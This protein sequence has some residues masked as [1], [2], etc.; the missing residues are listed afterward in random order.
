[1]NPK[2]QSSQPRWLRQL[3][4]AAGI[5]AGLA[6]AA[7]IGMSGGGG[8]PEPSPGQQSAWDKIAPRL[9]TAEQASRQA[10][11]KHAERV[12][13]FFAQRKQAARAFAED[14][15]SLSG[16]WAFVK[17][18]LPWSDPDGHNRFIRESFERHV[19]KA[20][21][22]KDLIESAVREYVS[23]LG[24]IEN[25]LLVAIRADLCESDLAPPDLLP[26][27]GTDESFQRAYGEMAQRILPTVQLDMSVTAGREVASF[28][29]ADIA[30]NISLRILTAVTA[31]LGLS[32]G[33]LG[34]GA[35]LSIETLG[36]GL[37][38]ALL[39]DKVID[40]AMHQAGYDPE[41]D[42]AL[43]VGQALDQ[44]E[45]MLLDGE[46]ESGTLGC[47]VNSRSCT[48][49]ASGSVIRRS[50][51]SFWKEVCNEESHR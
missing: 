32:G 16:K 49:R 11:G 41:G 42:I 22:I 5:V 4:L 34:S 19:L 25:A 14:V 27:L 44:V 7:I 23:E 1:M 50:R 3:L 21:D 17:S 8:E 31:R 2:V 38:A 6:M 35:A 18:N 45:A 12:K 24:G 28:V 39:V 13:S 33:I 9:S 51:N 26:V 36:V 40:F 29:A 48:R 47:A 46:P 43:K 10:V 37:V 20:D 30:A 15:F